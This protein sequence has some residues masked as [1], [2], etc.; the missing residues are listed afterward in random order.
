MKK[1]QVNDKTNSM[2]LTL[3]SDDGVSRT[4]YFSVISG[5]QV[6]SIRSAIIRRLRSRIDSGELDGIDHEEVDKLENEF[7]EEEKYLDLTPDF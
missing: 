6:K 4:V 5:F 3:V 1:R 2:P 7:L